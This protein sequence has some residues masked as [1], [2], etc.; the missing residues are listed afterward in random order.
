MPYLHQSNACILNYSYTNQ[1]GVVQK[2]HC[3]Q[4]TMVGPDWQKSLVKLKGDNHITFAAIVGDS[5]ES[6]LVCRN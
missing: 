6:S 2:S 5:L 4:L 3:Y 1:D